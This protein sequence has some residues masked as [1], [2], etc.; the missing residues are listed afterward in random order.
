M[1][2]SLASLRLA[3]FA[4]LRPLR[5][6]LPAL[7]T[8]LPRTAQRAY[9]PAPV[10]P[11]KQAEGVAA[12]LRL[13]TA[14]GPLACNVARDNFGARKKAKRW[15]R[16]IG[17]GR[18]RTAGRGMKGSKARSGHRS[19]VGFEGGAAPLHRKTPKRGFVRSNQREFKT[20]NHDVL[21]DAV[22]A[23][24]I[25]PPANGAPI[26]AR[27]LH[28]AGLVGLRR[29]HAG[30]KLLARGKGGF[31]VKLN[32]EVQ[33]ATRRAAERHGSHHRV[34]GAT[35]GARR[36]RVFHRRIFAVAAAHSAGEHSGEGPEG[37]VQPRRSRF[38]RARLVI[39]RN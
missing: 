37:A 36:R 19:F 33:E 16:G 9:E 15:G 6:H 23:G 29:R 13:P 10:P 21:Q 26:T 5:P 31:D 25:V 30:V 39:L 18:G 24:R 8:L 20:L 32:I 11:P 4:P 27:D 35:R 2:R 12:L 7:A 14:I 38:L 22:R 3:Q 34:R 17:S 1:L 28:D